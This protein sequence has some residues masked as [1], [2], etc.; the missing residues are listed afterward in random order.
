MKVEEKVKE[1]LLPILEERD[2]KLVDIEFIPSKRPILRIYIY[3]PEGTS[4]DDCEWVSKRIGALLDVE[5]LID[6]A[7]ILE[8]SSPGLD[9]KFKN[10]EEYDIFKG[11]DVVVKTKEPIN[12]K[13]VFKGTLLGLEDEKVKIKENEETVEIPFENVSQTKLDF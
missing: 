10:I 5:D 1:L 7:Y 11:R 9:R 2:F 13:K 6:K 8:V 12:E 3:N 4:I